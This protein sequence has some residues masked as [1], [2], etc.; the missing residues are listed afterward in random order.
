[1]VPPAIAP[2]SRVEWDVDVDVDVEDNVDVEDVDVGADVD[3]PAPIQVEQLIDRGDASVLVNRT[4]DARC[5]D[6]VKIVIGCLHF[7]VTRQ[8]VAKMS[9]IHT[10]T[11]I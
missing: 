5:R 3:E 9:S 10:V 2:T 6:R 7:S 8:E 4:G 11:F 1:M